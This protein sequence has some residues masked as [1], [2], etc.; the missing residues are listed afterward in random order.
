[1][2]RQKYN[3]TFATYQQQVQIYSNCS[4]ITFINNGATPCQINDNLT[5]APGAS[6]SITCQA[7]EIDTTIYRLSFPSATIVNNSVQV[8]KK[9]FV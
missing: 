6:L 7:N 3:I 2:N 9:N 4:D 1:M 5:L 8:I